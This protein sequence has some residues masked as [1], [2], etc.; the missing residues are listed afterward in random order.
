M[1]HDLPYIDR[2]SVEMNGRRKP[3]LIIADIKHEALVDNIHGIS[4]SFLQ[5][6]KVGEAS[7]LKGC[8]PMLQGFQR[9]GMLGLEVVYGST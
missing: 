1:G 6:H 3:V 4:E 5:R 7:L 9:I 2:L 8:I